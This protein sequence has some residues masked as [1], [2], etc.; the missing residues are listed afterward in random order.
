MANNLFYLD[1]DNN[2]QVSPHTLL[3]KEFKAIWKRDASTKKTLAKEELVYVYFM[4]DYLSEFEPYGLSK[5]EKIIESVITDSNWKPDK[6]VKEA[7]VAY[8][9]LQNTSSMKFLKSARN[10]LESIRLY[11]EDNQYKSDMSDEDKKRYDPKVVSRNMS[12]TDVLM[13]TITK[14]EKKVKGEEVDEAKIIGGGK[15]MA[16]EEEETAKD[17]L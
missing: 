8:E 5:E 16:F 4:A 15:L 11:Y 3:V 17:H 2:V 1:K 14:W 9:K 12:E 7:I 10:T 6:I 13:E